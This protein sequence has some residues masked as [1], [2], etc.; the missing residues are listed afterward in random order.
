[1]RA[2]KRERSGAVPYAAQRGGAAAARA[3]KENRRRENA[4]T[5]RCA[6]APTHAYATAPNKRAAVRGGVRAC[7]TNR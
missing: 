1:M 4:L 6:S 2:Q 3:R 5:A 7:G